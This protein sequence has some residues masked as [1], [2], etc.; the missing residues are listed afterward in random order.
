MTDYNSL[1]VP[2]L[3]KLLSDRSLAQTGNKPDLIARLQEADAKSTSA[4]G[5]F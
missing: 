3:K 4:P 5:S 1:K 2:E